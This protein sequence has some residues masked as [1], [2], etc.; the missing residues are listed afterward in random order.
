[1]WTWPFVWNRHS[2]N[3]RSVDADASLL[4]PGPDAIEVGPHS[5]EAVRV[6]GLNV[7]R[8][9]P[10][11][12][13]ET[14]RDDCVEALGLT[15]AEAAAHLQI[16]ESTLAAVCACEAPIT[17]DLAIRFEQALGSTADTW[18]R[19]QNAY[20]LAKGRKRTCQIK[21]IESALWLHQ[22]ESSAASMRARAR[23]EVAVSCSQ[24]RLAD[25][26]DYWGWPLPCPTEPGSTRMLD[27]LR[28]RRSQRPT[29]QFR[30]D[31]HQRIQIP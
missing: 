20:N 9:N 4:R 26:V 10:Q 24:P 17:A 27:V 29:R 21:R 1:M 6:S 5:G 7:L 16:E 19:L 23:P 18:L 14:I 25:W 15:M 3:R 31:S 2:R 12:P 13:G 22:R 28:L 11:H 8:D 30:S